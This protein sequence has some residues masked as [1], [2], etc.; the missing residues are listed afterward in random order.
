MDGDT[1]AGSV[2]EAGLAAL[3]AGAVGGGSPGAG[4]TGRCAVARIILPPLVFLFRAAK[5]T[6]GAFL[7]CTREAFSAAGGWDQQVFAGGEIDLAS[8]AEEAGPVCDR[9][10]PW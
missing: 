3:D 4:L 1:L 9:A 5:F 2:G 8:G 7:F 10:E 6:G